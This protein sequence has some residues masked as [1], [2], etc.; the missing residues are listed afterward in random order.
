MPS[1]TLSTELG[2]TF[3]SLS[4]VYV[5][6][7]KV[8]GFELDRRMFEVFVEESIAEV[9][10]SG[11]NSR[12]EEVGVSTNEVECERVKFGQTGESADDLKIKPSS[13]GIGDKVDPK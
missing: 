10:E 13:D 7:R 2:N 11:L 3:L 9:F 12:A 8:N 5:I 1:L 6:L 4:F